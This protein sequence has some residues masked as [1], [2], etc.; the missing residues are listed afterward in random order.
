MADLHEHKLTALHC[1]GIGEL[2]CVPSP[3]QAIEWT[4]HKYPIKLL[5]ILLFPN[6]VLWGYIAGLKDHTSR[7]IFCLD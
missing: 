7:R 6:N 2:A 1:C 3:A 4:I 5:H